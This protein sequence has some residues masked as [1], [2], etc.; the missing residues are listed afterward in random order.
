MRS[1]KIV[2]PARYQSTR[3]PGKPLVKIL[4]KEMILHVLE[5]ASKVVSKDKLLV[6]TESQ[7]IN[8]FIEDHGF[9]SKLTSNIHPTGTDRVWEAIRQESLDS[10]VTIQ[11]DEPMFHA[12]DL[13][14]II[15]AKYDFPN[16]VVNGMAELMVGEDPDDV[17]IPKLICNEKDELIYM[18][19]RAIPGIKQVGKVDVIFKKQVCL[20]GFENDHLKQFA[21]F[22]RKSIL[23]TYED[24]EILRFFELGIPIQMIKMKEAY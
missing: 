8:S 19:R 14:T 13:E 21:D 2:I 22:G 1:F 24:I 6:A 4:G 7:K 3:F 23:E 20:Y 11:G 15:Q 17:N 10:I 5:N 12:E 18:S 9:S 16:H